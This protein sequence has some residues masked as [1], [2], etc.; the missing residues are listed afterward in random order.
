MRSAIHT[1]RRGVTLLEML[2]VV[3][4]VVL[5]ML[6]L[7]SIFQAATGVM[8]TSRAF[9]E[10]SNSLR[11]V[12]ITLRGDLT[13]ATARMTPPLDP[14]DNLGYFEYM[15]NSF[16]DAQGE[17][18][19]DVLAF[20][21]KA[22]EGQ[23]FTGRVWIPTWNFGANLKDPS[24]AVQPVVVTSKFAEVI[25]FLRNGNLYRRVLLIAPERAGSLGL[26]QPFFPTNAPYFPG[27]LFG[28]PRPN[29]GATLGAMPV[30]WQGMNDISCRPSVGSGTVTIVPTPNTLGDLTERHNR[31]FRP[32]FADDYYDATAGSQT[33][34]QYAP[35]GRTDDNNQDDIPDYY[36]TLYPN[37]TP[38]TATLA[39][40]NE[41]LL[42]PSGSARVSTLSGQD[43][44]Q[45]LAF[46]YV[47]PALYTKPDR[48]RIATAN[49]NIDNYTLGWIHSPDPS[50][51]TFNHA[52]LSEGDTLAVPTD[53]NAQQRQQWFGYPTWRETMAGRRGSGANSLTGWIDP[54]HRLSE[55]GNGTVLQAWGLRPFP[56]NNPTPPTTSPNFPA[57][58]HAA[59]FAPTYQSLPIPGAELANAFSANLIP[60]SGLYTAGNIIPFVWQDDLIMTGVRSFD[61]KAYDPDAP[62]YNNTTAS[63]VPGYLDLGYGAPYFAAGYPSS[64]ITPGLPVLPLQDGLFNPIGFGHEGRIPPLPTDNRVNPSRPYR[65][66]IL[67]SG[68]A[69]PNYIG[70]GSDTVIRMRRTFDTWSTTYTNAPAVD[71]NF[72]GSTLKAFPNDLPVYPSYPPPYPSPLRGIQIQI[73]VVD[74]RNQHSKILT[75]RHDFSNKL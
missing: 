44:Y 37:I 72:N 65:N 15:E 30:S 58:F 12:D 66:N 34:G 33:V 21:A 67:A 35:D 75:I 48:T 22:P 50:G 51:L 25:W 26:V 42:Y 1:P 27:Q 11:A 10:L 17:D 29:A 20:T 8:S 68:L 62:I 14:K 2:V 71:V 53:G 32:R 73:R 31:A 47:N 45:S 4:L 56:P 40:V 5:M 70:D 39:L 54:V 28:Y 43:P 63:Y 24:E 36:P 46:P 19:D 3:G 9:Q 74:P 41:Q 49:G 61:V 38:T 13:G 69:Q 7:V 59:W 57:P 23:Y 6:I 60:E 18:T 55:Q 64:A 52:P 16:A